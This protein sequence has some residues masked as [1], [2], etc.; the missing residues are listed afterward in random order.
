[1]WCGQ[2]ED[3]A[4]PRAESRLAAGGEDGG[5]ASTQHRHADDLG[6]V[7]G[8]AGD[9]DGGRGGSGDGQEQTRITGVQVIAALDDVGG[10]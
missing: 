1:M 3:W 4:E 5:S 10:P 9:G 7:D 6:V 8:G 2:G